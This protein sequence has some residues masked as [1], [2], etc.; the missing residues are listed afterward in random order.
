MASVIIKPPGFV[1][2]DRKEAEFEPPTSHNASV[3][4]ADVTQWASH[5]YKM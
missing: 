5:S 1:V 4:T 3:S 2:N